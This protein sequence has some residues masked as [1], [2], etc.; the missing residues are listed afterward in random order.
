MKHLHWLLPALGCLILGGCGLSRQGPVSPE[1]AAADRV[2]ELDGTVEKDSAGTVVAVRFVRT[3][4]ADADLACLENLPELRELDLYHTNVTDA[5]L[6]HLQGLRQLR[7][8]DLQHTGVTD[9]GI[10]CLE[11]LLQLQELDLK[12]TVVTDAG[13]DHLKGLTQLRWLYLSGTRTTP[14]GIA[15]LQQALPDCH[16]YHDETSENRGRGAGGDSGTSDDSGTG[17]SHRNGR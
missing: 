7:G 6:P 1:R 4:V 11:G 8:L 14:Q 12:D 2:E 15:K 3:H 10:H 16:I 9:T 5:G 13:F 17:H